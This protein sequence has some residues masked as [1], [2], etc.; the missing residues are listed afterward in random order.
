[1]SAPRRPLIAILAILAILITGGLA[2]FWL[3]RQEAPP[4]TPDLFPSLR[5]GEAARTAAEGVAELQPDPP[6]ARARGEMGRAGRVEENRVSPP[7][8]RS[9]LPFAGAER[10]FAGG[11]GA[12]P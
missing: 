7:V 2:G 12:G 11:D 10:S 6:P 5:A 9:R 1:M 8:R 3:L 4:P